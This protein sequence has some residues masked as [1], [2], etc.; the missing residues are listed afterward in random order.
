MSSYSL[1]LVCLSPALFFSWL[2]VISKLLDSGRKRRKRAEEIKAAGSLPHFIQNRHWRNYKLARRYRVLFSLC[3]L[4]VL[5][6]ASLT[7]NANLTVTET[8]RLFDRLYRV[9]HVPYRITIFASANT[10]CTRLLADDRVLS[11]DSAD[12]GSASISVPELWKKEIPWKFNH[13]LSTPP[14]PPPPPPPHTHTHFF[15]FFSF[16]LF[17]V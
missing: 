11:M 2:N 3:V 14:P 15:F 13:V 7:S 12:L 10:L 1:R 17:S 4:N 6:P 16:F 5:P 9:T 8:R